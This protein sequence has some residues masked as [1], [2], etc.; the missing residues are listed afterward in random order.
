MTPPLRHREVK[1]DQDDVVRVCRL[2]V[3]HDADTPYVADRF[4]T[5]R[6]RVQQL[7]KECRGTSPLPGF[8]TPGRKPYGKYPGDLVD[9]KLELFE[10]HEQGVE[11]LAPLL[12]QHD[13]ITFDINRVH[14]IRLEYNNVTENPTNQRR[15]RPWLWFERDYSLVTLY[16]DWYQNDREDWCL[17]WRTTH[18]ARSSG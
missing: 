3:D 4:D 15:R 7:A 2:V 8:E 11:T 6:G 12:R 16:L 5:S 14:A 9:R 13:G 1:L 10:L 17:L 18:H